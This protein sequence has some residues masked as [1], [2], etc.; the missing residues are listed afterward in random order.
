MMLVNIRTVRR[1]ISG[2]AASALLA[3]FSS[4]ALALPFNQDYTGFETPS[5]PV[6][7]GNL[8]VMFDGTPTGGVISDPANVSSFKAQYTEADSAGTVT[9]DI[10]WETP[11]ALLG[12]DYNDTSG[13][14]LSLF[15]SS[16]PIL[17]P[18]PGGTPPDPTAPPPIFTLLLGASATPGGGNAIEIFEDVFNPNTQDFERALVAAVPLPPPPGMPV[19]G[20]VALFGIG[21]LLLRRF[22]S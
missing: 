1:S 5:G 9:K 13:Q 8:N 21:L 20:S 10:K 6:D 4:G 2:L 15:A 12:I 14:L 19:P 22:V 3:C 7:N 16:G 17:P 11:S 18:P